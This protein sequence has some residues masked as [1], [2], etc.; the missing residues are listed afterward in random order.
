MS[1][2]SFSG[3]GGADLPVEVRRGDMTLVRR[4]LTSDTVVLE[5]GAYLV[6]VRFPDGQQ[7]HQWVQVEPGQ[8]QKVSFYRAPR[9]SAPASGV[10]RASLRR[11]PLLVERS[12]NAVA[13]RL[14]ESAAVLAQRTE[15]HIVCYAGNAL[16]GSCQIVRPSSAGDAERKTPA[17]TRPERL[18]WYRL[19]RRAA[20]AQPILQVARWGTAGVH[21]VLPPDSS[22]VDVWLSASAPPHL[23][24]R[25]R[26]KTLETTLQFL[27]HGDSEAAAA[28][29]LRHTASKP[30]LPHLVHLY[31]LLRAN[32]L[33]SLGEWANH[34]TVPQYGADGA[35]ILGEFYARM[36][37]PQESLQALLRMPTLG[38]PVFT[39]GFTLAINRLRLYVAASDALPPELREEAITLLQTLSAFEPYVDYTQ[40][41]LTYTG[42]C[43][44]EPGEEPVSP[45]E[46]A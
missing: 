14:P 24:A 10:K 42:S 37:N 44:D 27:W 5:P 11:I 8:K 31:A 22:E 12:P 40:P 23:E 33:Q 9:E 38:L 15:T 21:L 28:I 17:R 34:L 36:G 16:Q 3:Y 35:V 18:I 30:D 43:P 41:F 29:A 32:E 45:E 1:Q 13:I 19:D 39:E 20:G 26:D 25:L 46:W 2:L 4:A 6:L 7:A